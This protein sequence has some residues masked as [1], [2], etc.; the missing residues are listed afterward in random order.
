VTGPAHPR[1]PAIDPAPEHLA[2]VDALRALQ[3]DVTA[4]APPPGVA[5]EVADLLG[6]ASARLRPWAVPERE[7]VT[8]RGRTNGVL[9][10]SQAFVPRV[11][12]DRWDGEVAT[13]TVTFGR[14]H[15]GGNGAVHGG[16]LPLLFDDVLGRLVNS[17]GRPVSRTASLHVDFRAVT[18]IGRPLRVAARVDRHEGRKW[19]V[20]GTLH[21]GNV[22]CA[23]AEALF[24]V[25]RADQP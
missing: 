8:G 10:R 5:A 21:A 2:L 22:L 14:H 1:Y 7:Q 4:T 6:A 18:P 23:E 9:G 13:G 11:D 15:L 25:L 20:S 3:D 19:W 17:C 16:A 12:L 24:V